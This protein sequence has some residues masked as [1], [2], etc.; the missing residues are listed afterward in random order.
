MLQQTQVVTVIPY[1]KR[2]IKEYPTIRKLAAATEQDVLRLWEGLGYYRRARQMHKAA[3]VIVNEHDGIF[4]PDFDSVRALPGIGR[5]TAGAIVSIAFASRAPI[6]EA[7]TIR[8]LSRLA[9]YREDPLRSEGQQFLW[10]LAEK[11]LPRRNVGEFNQALM[12]LGSEI[13]TPRDP[14]CSRCPARSLCLS[15]GHNLQ[16]EIPR[17]KTKVDYEDVQ[18]AAVIIRRGGKLLLRQ[19]ASSERWAG[20]WDFPRFAVESLKPDDVKSELAGNVKRLSGLSI[21]IDK[22]WTQIKHG[23]TRFR[24]TLTCYK[25]NQ[26][27]GR[28][29]ANGRPIQWI[30]PEE[31]SAYPLSATGRKIAQMLVR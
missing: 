3:N 6:L 22:P 26:V 19:C 24:I 31:L 11:L 20:M 9:A 2:F 7:N 15:N 23:V 8:L 14:D 4:P 13:C 5:Y 1:F 27:T 10:G 18:E 17:P 25:T 12:E 30:K 29:K 28:L 16:S 21:E